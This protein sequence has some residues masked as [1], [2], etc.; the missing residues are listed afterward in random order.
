MLGEDV[1][2]TDC[3][4]RILDEHVLLLQQHLRTGTALKNGKIG[5]R[6]EEE[7]KGK[8]DWQRI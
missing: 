3:E 5:R 4:L 1:N 7:W 8:E 2:M 6:M